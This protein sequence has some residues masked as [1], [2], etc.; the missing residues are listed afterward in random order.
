LKSNVKREPFS[1]SKSNQNVMRSFSREVKLKYALIQIWQILFF[2]SISSGLSYLLVKNGLINI[3]SE[4]IEI[5]GNKNINS[6][7]IIESSG[8]DFPKPLLK[9][10]PREMQN[11]LKEN[12][13][14]QTI[15]IRRKMMPTYLEIEIKTS[16]P[17]AFAS[18]MNMDSIEAGVLDTYGNWTPI[19]VHE[20]INPPMQLF[21]VEG[22]MESHKKAFSKLSMQKDNFGSPIEKI[23]FLNNGDILLETSLLKEIQLGSNVVSLEKKIKALNFLLEKLPSDFKNK[24]QSVDLRDHAKPELKILNPKTNLIL[25]N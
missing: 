16:E 3:D 8:I 10:E 5:I 17:I 22:W 14:I 13:P 25:T 19:E 23:K 2:A 6:D 4:R 12:L 21:Y 18:K 9:I 1:S 11:N 7:I 15:S 20:K 24:I